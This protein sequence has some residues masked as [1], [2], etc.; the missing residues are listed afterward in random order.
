MS[1]PSISG[2]QLPRIPQNG[3]AVSVQQKAQAINTPQYMEEPSIYSRT[4]D[5]TMQQAGIFSFQGSN[6]LP[7][8]AHSSQAMS[9]FMSDI[10]KLVY[11]QGANN[12]VERSGSANYDRR[13]WSAEVS[14]RIRAIAD[15]LASPAR[16]KN[17]LMQK[18]QVDFNALVGNFNLTRNPSALNHFLFA[19]SQNVK[20]PNSIGNVIDVYA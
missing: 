5:R 20:G 7:V 4:V 14:S 9:D 18:L 11:A 12:I 3:K 6:G 13:N 10:F 15:Q 19:F 8:N 16:A 17:G 2:N 1:L